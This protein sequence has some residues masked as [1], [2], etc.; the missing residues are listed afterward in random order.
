MIRTLQS[1]HPSFGD[2]LVAFEKHVGKYIEASYSLATNAGTSA[3][4]LVV[5]SLNIKSGN[6]VIL[7][8][9]RLSPQPIVCNM[10]M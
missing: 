8:H 2:Q 6:E 10:K 3:L 5:K 9:F 1:D 4:N 7:P